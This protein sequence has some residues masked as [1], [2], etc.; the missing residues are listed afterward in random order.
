MSH[1]VISKKN[2]VH[3]QVKSDTHVYYELSDYLLLRCQVQS[4]CHS[5]VVNIGMEK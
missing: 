5:I 1:L 2:E 4:L 3:L